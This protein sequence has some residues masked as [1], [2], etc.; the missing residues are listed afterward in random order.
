MDTSLYRD[1]ATFCL[2]L[3]LCVFFFE[4]WIH[5][6]IVMFPHFKLMLF[7]WYIFNM[8]IHC[9]LGM[10]PHCHHYYRNASTFSRHQVSQNVD[11]STLSPLYRAV[12]TLAAYIEMYPHWLDIRFLLTSMYPHFP[13]Y[14]WMYPHCLD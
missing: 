3:F 7:M 8:W 5:H 4:M 11:V 2:C 1:V 12:S 6:Y 14:I 10:Y 13:L 9:Y